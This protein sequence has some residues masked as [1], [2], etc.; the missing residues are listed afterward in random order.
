[1]NIKINLN[2]IRVKTI[3]RV[4]Q[5]KKIKKFIPRKKMR[6]QNDQKHQIEVIELV[7]LVNEMG[8]L[9]TARFTDASLQMPSFAEKRFKKCCKIILLITFE[10]FNNRKICINITSI[11]NPERNGVSTKTHCECKP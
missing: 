10:Y 1:M 3:K 5:M 8:C 11:T 6:K 2:I 7:G 9:L 4:K